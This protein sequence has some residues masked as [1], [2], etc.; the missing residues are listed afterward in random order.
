MQYFKIIAGADEDSEDE[1]VRMPLSDLI[2]S[3]RG[4][5]V[6]AKSMVPQSRLRILENKVD[7]NSRKLDQILSLL[8]EL[9]NQ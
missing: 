5:R 7:E 2:A 4:Q 3:T 9:K 1:E 8:N 6:D